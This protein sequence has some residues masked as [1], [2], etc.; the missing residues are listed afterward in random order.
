MKYIPIH[1]MLESFKEEIDDCGQ[2]VVNGY[3]TPGQQLEYLN[4]KFQEIIAAE[5]RYLEGNYGEV[6]EEYLVREPEQD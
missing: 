2:G 5:L 3:M 4:E 6:D 1:E